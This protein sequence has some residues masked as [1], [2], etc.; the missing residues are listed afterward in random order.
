M[1][2]SLNILEDKEG[3]RCKNRIEYPH[4]A[5]SNVLIRSLDLHESNPTPRGIG[6]PYKIV[7]FFRKKKAQASKA[8]SAKTAK[9]KAGKQQKAGASVEAPSHPL[10]ADCVVKGLTR[11]FSRIS[12]KAGQGLFLQPGA[13]KHT[14]LGVYTGE[15][16][17]ASVVAANQTQDQY[18]VEGC[19][20]GKTLV[21]GNKNL[22][23]LASANEAPVGSEAN[24]WLEHARVEVDGVTMH[25]PLF[26]LARAMPANSNPMNRGS[27]ILVSYGADYQRIRDKFNYEAGGPPDQSTRPSEP[28]IASA[29]SAFCVQVGVDRVAIARAY[30]CAEEID[31][32]RAS[33]FKRQHNVDAR[34]SAR[35]ALDRH[36]TRDMD[37]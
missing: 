12:F 9:A 14:C 18:F 30:G 10:P 32:V 24:T 37:E 22:D 35:L 26:V 23:P 13:A 33:R 1:K 17:D 31:G 8:S 16:V 3:K 7:L 6:V 36:E 5:G 11:S 15:H 4:E 28:D 25:I 27:E 34:A 29:F 2:S 20:D 19:P 21:L